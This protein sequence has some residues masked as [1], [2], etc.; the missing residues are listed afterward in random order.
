MSPTA[1]RLIGILFLIAAAV[2]AVMNLKRVANL[3]TFWISGTLFTIGTA[4][5]LLA[6]KSR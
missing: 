4:F 3:G 2:M 6:R 5:I 1:F